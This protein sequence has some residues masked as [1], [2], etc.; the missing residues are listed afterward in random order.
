MT[1]ATRRSGG[2]R[3]TGIPH[4]VF[5]AQAAPLGFTTGLLNDRR[6]S[7]ARKKLIDNLEN[8]KYL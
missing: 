7:D 2:R 3:P 4:G 6:L 8:I 5:L 1:E